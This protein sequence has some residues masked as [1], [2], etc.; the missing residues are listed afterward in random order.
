[1]E[2]IWTKPSLKRNTFHI[3]GRICDGDRTMSAFSWIQIEGGVERLRLVNGLTE[4]EAVY[5][6]LLGVL[7]YLR[8]TS[9]ATIFMHSHELWGHF[10]DDGLG[11][12]GPELAK[13]FAK[14]CRLIREK[15]LEIRVRYVFARTIKRCRLPDWRSSK[16]SAGYARL[17]MTMGL[18][19][20]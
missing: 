16:E 14:A 19:A 10:N 5:H 15:E 17:A 13:L 1:M 6:A 2:I 11:A 12:R 20:G 18:T 3:D 9:R 7:K 8:P 4:H